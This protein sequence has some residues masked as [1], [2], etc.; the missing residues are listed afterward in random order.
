MDGWTITAENPPGKALAGKLTREA[1][2]GSG[3]FECHD[4]GYQ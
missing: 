3:V 2:P 4:A 1:D